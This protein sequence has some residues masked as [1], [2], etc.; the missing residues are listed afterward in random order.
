MSHALQTLYFA[1]AVIAIFLYRGGI[2]LK[3]M[4]ELSNWVCHRNKIPIDPRTGKPAKSNDKST[5]GSYM[6]AMAYMGSD[7]SI[8]GIGFMFS[9]SPYV[10]IKKGLSSLIKC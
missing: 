3:N 7:K 8:N 1:N 4:K 5:W 2:L 9:H 6:Q 10:V